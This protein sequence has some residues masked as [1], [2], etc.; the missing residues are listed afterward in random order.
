MRCSL[1]KQILDS[2]NQKVAMCLSC[3]DAVFRWTLSPTGQLGLTLEATI[4]WQ[5][6]EQ[7]KCSQLEAVRD[8]LQTPRWSSPR[9][10]NQITQ[11]SFEQ[12][13]QAV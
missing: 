5:G 8:V 1:E 2:M 12:R 9:L 4:C 10:C 13:L 3:K 6:S 11:I 7:C